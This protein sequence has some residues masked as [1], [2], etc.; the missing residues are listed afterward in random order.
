MFTATSLC[1]L[2]L[3]VHLSVATYWHSN[4]SILVLFRDLI[5]NAFLSL[6]Q[7]HALNANAG[8]LDQPLPNNDV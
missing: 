2:P 3:N 4:K 8:L 1:W 7:L 6:I 5:L